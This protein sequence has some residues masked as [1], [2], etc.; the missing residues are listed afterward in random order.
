MAV[1]LGHRT[2]S[3]ITKEAG[4]GM[5]QTSAKQNNPE[6]KTNVNKFFSLP[7]VKGQ[8]GFCGKGVRVQEVTC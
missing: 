3:T 1:T 6:N 7:A 8:P 4:Q 2:T 5:N